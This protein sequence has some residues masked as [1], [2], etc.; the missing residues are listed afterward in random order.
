M[1]PLEVLNEPSNINRSIGWF[2]GFGVMLYATSRTFDFVSMEMVHGTE[3]NFLKRLLALA[4]NFF[5]I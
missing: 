2:F 3:N 5:F 1:Q 4:A